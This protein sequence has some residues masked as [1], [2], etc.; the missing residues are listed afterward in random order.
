MEC[1]TM[2][3]WTVLDE[4]FSSGINK[5]MV[6][7]VLIII[8]NIVFFMKEY[9]FKIVP[10]LCIN[11]ILWIISDNQC[12]T[13]DSLMVTEDDFMKALNENFIQNWLF[14]LSV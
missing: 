4:L 11:Y 12:V 3:G 2:L 8:T 9:K 13:D 14:A 10:M 6:N 7:I 1:V 5:I